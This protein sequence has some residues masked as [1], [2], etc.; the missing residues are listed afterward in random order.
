MYYWYFS[1]FSTIYSNNEIFKRYLNMKQEI[2][3]NS[4]IIGQRSVD[5]KYYVT[6]NNTAPHPFDRW[7][8]LKNRTKDNIVAY[9]NPSYS[10]EEIT[11]FIKNGLS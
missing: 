3:S 9:F 1:M 2:N 7:Y 4:L 5:N 6:L 10:V 11:A 8:C